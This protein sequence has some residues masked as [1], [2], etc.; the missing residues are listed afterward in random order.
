TITRYQLWDSTTDPS[1][2]HWVVNGVAQ[3]ASTAIDVTAAQLVQ[4]TFQSGSGT[5]DR[6]GGAKGGIDWGAWEE[7]HVVERVN[8]APV[9]GAT[10]PTNGARRAKP[11]ASSLFSVSDVD[12]DAITR[13]QFW[14]STANASSGHWMVNGVA[15][16]AGM[17]ID[18]T[19]AQLAQTTFQSGSGT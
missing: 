7:F 13:Y 5:E 14:D 8:N 16:G 6:K 12:G 10:D 3:G 11:L 19:A 18:V 17:A 2:G 1:S 9:V 4:T 15:Q